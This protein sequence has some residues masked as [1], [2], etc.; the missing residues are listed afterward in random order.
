MAAFIDFQI[1]IDLEEMTPNLALTLLCFSFLYLSLPSPLSFLHCFTL[2]LDWLW[3][4]YVAPGGLKLMAVPL[5]RF[6][7]CCDYG[8]SHHTQ[9]YFMCYWTGPAS[10]MLQI[11]VWNTALYLSCLV[12]VALYYLVL[13]SRYWLNSQNDFWHFSSF[14]VFCIRSCKKLFFKCLVEFSTATK[15]I[16][17]K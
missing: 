9:L 16:F 15:T 11:S 17:L 1:L 6:P 5:S 2:C 13:L 7:K 8:V 3:I 14:S 12:L 10:I 4:H